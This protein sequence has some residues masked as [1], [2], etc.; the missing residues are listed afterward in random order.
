MSPTPVSCKTPEIDVGIIGWGELI[1]SR[2]HIAE[3]LWG[4]SISNVFYQNFHK[5][6]LNTCF[7]FS[8]FQICLLWELIKNLS[9]KW[10]IFKIFYQNIVYIYQFYVLKDCKKCLV[11]DYYIFDE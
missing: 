7:R 3:I 6:I 1:T 5:H 2:H 8:N 4:Y 11:S 10:Y 9:S